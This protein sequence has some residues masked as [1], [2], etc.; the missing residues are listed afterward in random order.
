MKT[1]SVALDDSLLAAVD[2]AVRAA[3]TTRAAFVREA[4]RSAVWNHRIQQREQA[5]AMGYQKHPVVA[6]EFDPWLNEQ[7][8]M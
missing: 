4:L 1:I 6:D 5:Q 8:W 2:E 7:R 3:D